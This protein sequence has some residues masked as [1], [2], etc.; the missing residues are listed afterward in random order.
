[1]SVL[2]HR[3]SADQVLAWIARLEG[4][5]SLADSGAAVGSF[6]AVLSA[7]CLGAGALGL[8][9]VFENPLVPR[10]LGVLLLVS[11]LLWLV[12]RTQRL[13]G[14]KTALV[15]RVLTML[16]PDIPSDE[17]VSV[18]ID[19]RALQRAGQRTE[20][21]SGRSRTRRWSHA[22]LDLQVVLADGSRVKVTL[23]DRLKRKETRKHKGTRTQEDHG[24]AVGLRIR[25]ARRYGSAD[26][27][28]NQLSSLALPKGLQRSGAEAKGRD[29]LVRVG[30]ARGAD[31]LPD[32]DWV[33]RSLGWVYAALARRAH[34]I[35]TP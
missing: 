15:T 7:A 22:W 3:A 4:R 28:R 1:M 6:L 18:R 30:G 32:A 33:L 27:V 14:R 12:C 26:P 10:G 35:S 13:D 8:A 20:G 17:P 16:R 11:A 24:G 21:K 9:P 31:R 25:L 19:V 23:V 34:A 29:L 5:H 2:E